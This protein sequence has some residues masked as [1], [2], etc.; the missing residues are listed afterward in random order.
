MEGFGSWN[1]SEET[2]NILKSENVYCREEECNKNYLLLIEDIKLKESYQIDNNDIFKGINNSLGD[3]LPFDTSIPRKID[4]SLVITDKE[5]TVNDLVKQL[6]S[7]I[8][9]NL[10]NVQEVIELVSNTNHDVLVNVLS[11]VWQQVATEGE[12]KMFIKLIS[13]CA[14]S[15]HLFC[16]EI[17]LKKLKDEQTFH[18]TMEIIHSVAQWLEA[19]LIVDTLLPLLKDSSSPLANEETCLKRCVESLTSVQK[20]DLLSGYISMIEGKLQKHDLHILGILL[21]NISLTNNSLVKLVDLFSLY[22]MDFNE[23]RSFGITYR[24]WLAA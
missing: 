16:K 21:E 1:L 10:E 9:G 3:Y 22:F 18:S 2:L 13:A 5:S 4:T 20:S 19:P 6:K 24:C 23:D 8:R 7:N 17:L 12:M 14:L 11:N 15:S